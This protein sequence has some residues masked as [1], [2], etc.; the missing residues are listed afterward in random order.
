M[1]GAPVATSGVI[2]VDAPYTHHTASALVI[3]DFPPLDRIPPADFGMSA[4]ILANVDLSGVP[5]I[6]LTDGTCAGSPMNAQNAQANH[7]VR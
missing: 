1:V 2:D 4:E 5:D 6:P 7:W 3:A